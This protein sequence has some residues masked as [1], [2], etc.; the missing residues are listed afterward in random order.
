MLNNAGK[1]IAAIQRMVFHFKRFFLS[2]FFISYVFV[3]I[4]VRC[5]AV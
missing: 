3:E 4:G 1:T 2:V 5:S